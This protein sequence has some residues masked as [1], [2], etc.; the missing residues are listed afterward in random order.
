MSISL[1]PQCWVVMCECIP[2]P[3]PLV[4]RSVWR[5]N[6]RKVQ[7]QGDRC[8][9]LSKEFLV[10]WLHQ[11]NWSRARF[12]CTRYLKFQWP[13]SYLTEFFL[14]FCIL[15]HSTATDGAAFPTAPKDTTSPTH[16]VSTV[17]M[18]YSLLCQW[19]GI[20]F[21]YQLCECKDCEFTPQCSIPS[22][23]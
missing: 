16:T 17:L 20:H 6:R 7:R 8:S 3:L 15:L 21:L 18:T 12:R 9:F 11:L 4:L 1:Q 14:L 19:I 5:R 22:L 23:P 10:R 13:F 2:Q